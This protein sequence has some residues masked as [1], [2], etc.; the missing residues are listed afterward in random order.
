MERDYADDARRGRR[1]A[2][3]ALPP[4]GRPGAHLALR[5]R[6]RRPRARQRG[7]RRRGGSVRRALDGARGLDLAPT[8]SRPLGGARRGAG[9]CRRGPASRGRAFSR[10]RRLLPD[11][12]V[13]AR[14]SCTAPRGCTSGSA[15]PMPAVRW[16]R[17]G[18]RRST[19]LA[20]ARPAHERAGA[21]D[22][23]R[24]GA[25]PAGPRRRGGAALP[26]G[27]RRW[28]RRRRGTSCSLARASFNLDRALV[29]LGRLREAAHSER[30]L[31]IYTR[32]GDLE[33]QAAVLN[34]LGIY[35]YW[36]GRWQEA[37]DLYERAAEASERAGDVW[38]AAYG[39]CNIG[40]VLADQGR[41][42]EAEERLRAGAADLDRHRGRARRR[43]RLRPARAPRR[44]RRPPRRGA[45][46][47]DRRRPAVR[48][49]PGPGRRG[50]RGRLPRRGRAARGRRRRGARARRRCSRGD[51]SASAPCCCGCAA[52]RCATR[53][54]RTGARRWRRRSPR[55]ATRTD[56]YETAVTLDA[57]LRMGRGDE[58]AREERDRL[59]AALD[60]VALPGAP[61]AGAAVIRTGCADP[62]APTARA[63]R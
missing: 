44:P 55:R 24:R 3:A 46:A 26:R 1:P 53:R 30:A 38:A 19:G 47:A 40:E 7:V 34:N 13:R 31:E 28:P 39:D 23:A 9:A 59:L 18:L 6:G 48:R 60:I 41:L 57:L 22:D 49:A 29:D 43:V 45:R 32:A 36:E 25:P 5:A 21:D 8:T 15:A 14:A 11:D 56:R 54:T 35:A 42:E 4:R 10:A 37:I 2:V 12:P 63:T 51:G 27:D 50:A 20:G 61:A 16:C 17:R 62:S 58:P 52:A 33:R